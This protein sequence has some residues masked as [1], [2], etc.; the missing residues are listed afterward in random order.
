[1]P[2]YVRVKPRH[3]FVVSSAPFLDGVASIFDFT[4]ILHRPIRRVPQE[5]AESY[6]MWSAWASVGDTLREVMDEYPPEQLLA[7][8]AREASTV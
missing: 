2:R 7:E 5:M 6:T 4:G 3:G 8:D 1:M